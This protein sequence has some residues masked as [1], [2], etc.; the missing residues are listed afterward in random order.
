MVS[1]KKKTDDPLTLQ[2]QAALKDMFDD[3]D[4][5]DVEDVKL[6]GFTIRAGD[7]L[8]KL[9]VIQEEPISIENEVREEYRLKIRAKLQEIKHR[10]NKKINDVVDMTTKIRQEAEKKEREMKEKLRR[11]KAMPEISWREA[12]KG[13]SIVAGENKDEII[14]LI[15]GIYWPKFV[16]ERPIDPLYA[17]KMITPIVFLIRTTGRRITEL[18]TRKPMGL[19]LFPHYHQQNPDCWGDFNYPKN[20]SKVSDLLDIAREAEAVLENVNTHS[21][22]SRNPRGLP[23]KDTLMRHIVSKETGKEKAKKIK[24]KTEDV[25]IG[26]DAQRRSAEEDIWTT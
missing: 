4:H 19:D 11:V 18:S 20:F 3:L 21:I 1:Q 24:L 13:V 23:R 9:Q 15:R 16:D 7:K 8:V 12:T 22:A 10:L 14:Y 26:V 2:S 5:V 17:K 6:K 25:R